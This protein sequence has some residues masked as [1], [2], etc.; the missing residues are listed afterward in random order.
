[1]LGFT[2]GEWMDMIAGGADAEIIVGGKV[3]GK[4]GMRVATLTEIRAS[5]K[6]AA[7][8]GAKIAPEEAKFVVREAMDAQRTQIRNAHENMMEQS[9]N[10]GTLLRDTDDLVRLEKELQENAKFWESEAN[11]FLKNH[12]KG[13]PLCKANAAKARQ[14]LKE[15][16]IKR[17]K[18]ME[19]YVDTSLEN[20]TRLL[21]E[22]HSHNPDSYH[23]INTK[24]PKVIDV[25]E[26]YPEKMRVQQKKNEDIYKDLKEFDPYYKNSNNESPNMQALRLRADELRTRADEVEARVAELKEDWFIK[27][28]AEIRQ[29]YVDE[30][31]SYGEYT[32]PMDQRVKYYLET[33]KTPKWETRDDYYKWLRRKADEEIN[34][35]KEKQDFETTHFVKRPER[36]IRDSSKPTKKT[37]YRGKTHDLRGKIPKQIGGSVMSGLAMGKGVVEYTNDSQLSNGGVS[38]GGGV[39]KPPSDNVV[40]TVVDDIVGRYDEDSPAYSALPN[41]NTQ[42]QNVGDV[43]VY[44][45]VETEMNM[46]NY[47]LVYY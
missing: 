41:T 39:L 19:E 14:L 45:G 29:M 40:D 9:V 8:G 2:V 30:G 18:R 36:K 16:R 38:V 33:G 22:A 13:M 37:A 35:W 3:G 46:N 7:K 42:G 20:S 44:A 10:E 25:L 11:G 26:K 24:E 47:I 34:V 32:D 28:D 27:Q 12:P 17:F 4:V 6:P 1:V 23:K 5:L 31:M 15:I 43:V 21:N